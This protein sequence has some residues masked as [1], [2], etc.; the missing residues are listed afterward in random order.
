MDYEDNIVPDVIDF[1]FCLLDKHH[2]HKE[3]DMS[4]NSFQIKRT[5]TSNISA[6]STYGLT[7]KKGVALQKSFRKKVSRSQISRN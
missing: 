2:L 7:E 5:G 6:Y 3:T 4:S 1:L